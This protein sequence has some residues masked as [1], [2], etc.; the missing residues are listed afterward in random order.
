MPRTITRKRKR[1]AALA[2][3]EPSPKLNGA[4]MAIAHTGYGIAALAEELA[5]LNRL[6][7]IMDAGET[8]TGRT[9]R[10]DTEQNINSDAGI[11]DA[12][13]RFK[14]IGRHTFAKVEALQQLIVELEPTTANETLSLALLFTEVL[15]G[16]ISDHTDTDA[17]AVQA[18]SDQ[19][20]RIV[21]SI[22]RGLIRGCG[23][24][25]PLLKTYVTDDYLGSWDEARE[26]ATRD[27]EPYLAET[28]ARRP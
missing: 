1:A 11:I 17:P 10:K 25:S 14:Q 3:S 27:A 5:D 12:H 7:N 24:S 16:F 19:L 22:I 4:P 23:A 20:E 15:D 6:Y 26:I 9:L 13:S 2:A 21:R 28:E 8:L 18:D